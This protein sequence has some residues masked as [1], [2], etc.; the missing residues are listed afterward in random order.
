MRTINALPPDFTGSLKVLINDREPHTISRNLALLLIL[1]T[2]P[3][4]ALAAD[5]A[6]HFWYS[7]FQPSEYRSHTSARVLRFLSQVIESQ[8][9]S[10]APPH[11]L[12]PLS[13]LSLGFS[14]KVIEI[15]TNY[16]SSS[17]ISD[18][19]SEYDRVRNAPS[20]RDYRDRMYANLKPSHRVAFQEYRRFGIL[21]PFGAVNAHFNEPNLSLFSQDGKWLQTDYADPLEGWK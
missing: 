5:M 20:R 2:V 15:L 9:S 3:D 8:A 7:A 21:L 18:V 10:H 1:G 16:F 11:A 19:Q 12:T 17:S 6:L 4:E 13:T 14:R